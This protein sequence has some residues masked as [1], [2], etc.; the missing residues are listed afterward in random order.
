MGDFNTVLN[1]DE[2]VGQPIR[3]TEVAP[4]RECM[5]H[6]AASDIKQSG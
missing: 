4:F 5:D 6:C 3:L 1:M 2:R